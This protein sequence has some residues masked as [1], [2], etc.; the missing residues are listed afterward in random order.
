[1]P[2]KRDQSATRLEESAPNWP[3]IKKPS[4][5]DRGAEISRVTTEPHCIN[6]TTDEPRAPP[7]TPPVTPERPGK[8]TDAQT[9]T[10][11]Y[12]RMYRMIKSSS[13][14]RCLSTQS[15]TEIG[16]NKHSLC[17]HIFSSQKKKKKNLPVVLPFHLL[18]IISQPLKGSFQ[19]FHFTV[20]PA[21]FSQ[22]QSTGL[23]RYC[24]RCLSLVFVQLSSHQDTR[25]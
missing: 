11:M 17:F 23:K 14:S 8:R 4:Q 3:F 24:S 5:V 7:L 15:D 18:N 6:Y 16:M 10:W 9:H 2:L 12:A 13:T 20:C 22:R 19:P 25:R 21:C 1:M